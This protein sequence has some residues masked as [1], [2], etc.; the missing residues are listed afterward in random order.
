MTSLS[1]RFL[2]QPRETKW[3]FLD[4]AGDNVGAV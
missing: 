1:T 3:I 2:G 4:G